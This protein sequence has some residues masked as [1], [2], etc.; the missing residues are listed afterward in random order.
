[1]LRAWP[2]RWSNEGAHHDVAV[3]RDCLETHNLHATPLELRF[4]AQ[5]AQAIGGLSRA[6]ADPIVTNLIEKYADKVKQENIGK[7]FTELYDMETLKPLSV[8]EEIYLE[9][10][11]EFKANYGLDLIV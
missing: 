6:D 1:M 4:S 10:C 5:V 8:W 3:T 2:S 7:P 9:V 11:Q